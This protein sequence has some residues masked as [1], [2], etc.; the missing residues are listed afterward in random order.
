MLLQIL[1]PHFTVGILLRD[2]TVID[3]AL[4][5]GYMRG[6]RLSKV[7]NYCESK[8]WKVTEVE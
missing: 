3:C 7:K 2:F 1:A 5:I 6:W 8:G 4:I